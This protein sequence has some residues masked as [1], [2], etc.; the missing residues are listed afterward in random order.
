MRNTI[1]VLT[2]LALAAVPGSLSAQRLE[3]AFRS[4]GDGRTVSLEQ[5]AAS[6]RPASNLAGTVLG[7]ALAGTVGFLA[8]GMIGGNLDQNCDCDDPGL[9]GALYGVAIGE[10]LGLATGAHLGN[11]RRGNL[12]LDFL[13]SVGTAVLGAVPVAVLSGGDGSALVA[14]PIAQLLA[15]VV[16]ETW[17]GKSKAEG[18]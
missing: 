6:S 7:G 5:Y 12:G 15:V 8:G 13:V 10:T 9:I 16:T 2:L 1:A 11:G 4:V 18:R 17:V 14:L 3:P